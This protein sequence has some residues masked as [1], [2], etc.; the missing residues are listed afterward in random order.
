MPA[1]ATKTKTRP[2]TKAQVEVETEAEVEVVVDSG[3]IK[4]LEKWDKSKEAANKSQAT[5][6]DNWIQLAKYVRD[7]DIS[8][9]QLR[10]ALVNIRGM[11]ESSAN[12]ECTRLLRFQHS[13]E[14][15]D[16][17]D[18]KLEGDEEISVHDLR[19]ANVK[20]GEKAEVDPIVHCEKKL[21]TVAKFAIEEAEIVDVSEFGSL[22]RKAYKIATAKIEAAAKRNGEE[23]GGDAAD[24]EEDE[25]EEG[26]TE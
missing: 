22:A 23:E 24:S 11:K 12:V 9:E 25:A 16:M 5:A 13:E 1:T 8:K 15:S 19:S 26:E 21:T 4:L 10:Y 2:S 18:R 14:A 17:L 3:L 20:R 7:H 6:D